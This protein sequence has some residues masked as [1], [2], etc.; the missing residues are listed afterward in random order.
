MPVLSLVSVLSDHIV[1]ANFD[2]FDDDFTGLGAVVG[3]LLQCTFKSFCHIGSIKAGVKVLSHLPLQSK[4]LVFALRFLVFLY[5]ALPRK[6]VSNVLTAVLTKFIRA[7]F[8]KFCTDRFQY[9]FKKCSIAW[10]ADVPS[11]LQQAHRYLLDINVQ[12]ILRS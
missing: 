2:Q 6:Q 7:V 1:Q 4:T 8:A 12:Q 9:E 11:R 5:G 10:G 3:M